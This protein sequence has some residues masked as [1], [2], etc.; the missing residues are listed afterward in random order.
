MN[1]AM[2]AMFL[3]SPAD[4]S[5]PFLTML[6]FEQNVASVDNELVSLADKLED[7]NN[8]SIGG[9]LNDPQIQFSLFEKLESCEAT[10]LELQSE[11]T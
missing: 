7:E 5:Y 11:K 10:S 4:R 6:E 9:F 8:K 3:V 2:F 1:V